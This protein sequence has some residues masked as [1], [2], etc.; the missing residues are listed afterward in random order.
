MNKCRLKLTFFALM[1]IS[2]AFLVIN[3]CTTKTQTNPEEKPKLI[4][5][6]TVDQF[7]AGYL[8]RYDSV[9][10]GGFRRLKDQGWR[11][12]KARVD[13]APTLSWPGHTTIATGAYPKNH[14]ILSNAFIQG[15]TRR[16]A[17]FDEKENQILGFPGGMNLSGLRIKATGIADW[18]RAADPDAETVALSTG[19]GLAVGYGGRSL[20]DRSKNHVYWLDVRAGEFVTSTFYRDEYPN[21]INNFNSNILTQYKEKT[22]WDLLV[23]EEYHH[24][25]RR[26]EASYEKNVGGQ[27][28]F[29]HKIEHITQKIEARTINYWFYNYNPEAEVAL[30]HLAK[31]SVKA[32]SLGQRKSTD[33]LAVAIK[34]T[35][36]IGHDFGPRSL[37]QLDVLY[38]IDKELEKFLDFLDLTVGKDNYILSLQADHGGPNIVEYELE[39][40]RPA[41]R[42]TEKELK[43]LLSGIEKFVENYSGPEEDLPSSIAKE[44]EKSARIIPVIM[45]LSLNLSKMR[46]CIPPR[47]HTRLPIGTIR[48]CRFCSWEKG[49]YRAFQKNQHEQSTLLPPWLFKPAYPIRIP[50]TGKF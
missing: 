30:F 5:M 36:R 23:P 33:F 21:W 16:Q 14:G 31:E 18:I 44:L 42:V 9:F 40:G 46:S 1:V 29:P 48:K 28:T 26:D 10:T 12:D 2:I 4:V 24:L 20:A 13:H 3:S 19:P 22:S 37:E 6:I 50:L 25:A 47:P 43:N 45:E 15:K 34:S 49:S 8:E 38:R 39:Q 17:Y 41:K 32:L 7:R 27:T 35:D 11:Y